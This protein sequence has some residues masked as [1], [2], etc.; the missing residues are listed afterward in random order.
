MEHD[1]FMAQQLPDNPFRA[2]REA[3]TST[4]NYDLDTDG[5]IG[6]LEQWRSLCNFQVLGASL[7]K[8]EIEFQSLPADMDKFVRGLYELCPDLVDQRTRN[9]LDMI[10]SIDDVPPHKQWLFEGLDLTDPD[11]P[12]EILKRQVQRNMKL[13]LWWD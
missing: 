2:L 6:R 7:D 13:T 3:G 1:T 10:G 8:V 11:A 9:M 12:L 5:I 4:G